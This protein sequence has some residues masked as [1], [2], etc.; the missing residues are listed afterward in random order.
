MKN[1]TR[2]R[3]LFTVA[4]MLCSSPVASVLMAQSSE[5]AAGSQPAP[6][7]LSVELWDVLRLSRASVGD[8]VI[9]AYIKSSGRTYSL[10]P[11][12]ILYLREQGVSEQVVTA[13]LEQ[14]RSATQ[15]SRPAQPS[16]W[17][18]PSATAQD[19]PAPAPAPAAA[20]PPPSYVQPAPVYVTAPPVY[21]YPSRYGYYDPWPS[22]GVYWGAPSLSFSFGWGGHY[23][24]GY[25]GGIHH[26]GGGRH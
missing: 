2:L 6:I 15:S 24:I 4:A 5:P 21:V 20:P 23:G 14:H 19:A 16:V 13:M 18:T 1:R 9:I 10:G 22:F 25:R 8:G 11:S 26:R 12:E 3:M 17:A 7:Q